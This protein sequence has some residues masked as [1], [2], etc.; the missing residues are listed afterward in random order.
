MFNSFQNIVEYYIAKDYIAKRSYSLNSPTHRT[1][2]LTISPSGGLA[3][4]PLPSTPSPATF[5]FYYK[6]SVTFT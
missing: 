1:R 2:S 3:I 4:K 5:Q 6:V